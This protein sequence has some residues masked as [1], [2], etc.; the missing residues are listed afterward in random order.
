MAQKCTI[1]NHPGREQIDKA[2][3]AGQ[4]NRSIAAQYK[5]SQT[6]VQRHKDNHLPEHLAQS[7]KAHQ[8][9][10]ADDLIS[11]LQYLRETAIGFLKQ[12]QEA[13]DRKAAAPLISAAVKVVETLAE[14]R[15]ELNRQSVI[16]ITMSPV[17]IETRTLILQA[18]APYPEVRQAVAHALQEGTC[19]KK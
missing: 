15:G 11:D 12:A 9:C 14:V 10:Q 19:K 7:K 6:A 3:L 5:V 8:V 4:S 2:I 1:C 13:K 17:W 18:L 16:N